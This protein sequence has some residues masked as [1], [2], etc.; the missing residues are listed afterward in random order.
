MRSMPW[1]GLSTTAIFLL[2]CCYGCGGTGNGSNPTPAT[3]AP[4]SAAN[5]NLIFVV[6]EDLTNN[7]AGDVNSETANLTSQGLKRTLLMAPFLQQN[8]L[9]GNNVTGLYA[10]EPMTHLQTAKQ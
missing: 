3:P 9:G 7:A 8:V 5:I 1:L 2:L 10:L 6:S 4:L